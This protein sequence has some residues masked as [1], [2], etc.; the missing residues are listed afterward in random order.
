MP[1]MQQQIPPQQPMQTQQPVQQQSQPVKQ[2]I[3][4]KETVSPIKRFLRLLVTTIIVVLVAGLCYGVWWLIQHSL[5]LGY[6]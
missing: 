3:V 6:L 5:D 1:E 2:I 4:E